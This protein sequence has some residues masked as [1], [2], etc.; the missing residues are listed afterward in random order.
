MEPGTSRLRLRDGSVAL[1]REVRPGDRA[2]LIGGFAELSHESRVFRFLHHVERLEDVD[3]DRFSSPDSRLHVAI[4]ASVSAGAEAVPAGI[5]HF[6]RPTSEARRAELALTV[7][8][9]FQGRGLG[10]LLL[11]RLM[12]IGTDQGLRQ[13][14]ALVHPRNDGMIHILRGL[15]AA[16]RMEEGIR[17][18][19]LP[20]YRRPAD[21]PRGSVGD[22]VRAAYLIESGDGG[23]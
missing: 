14:D 11:G 18:F 19:A 21:Y 6:F 20:L 23:G 8:D 3:A 16:E 17:I 4:G 1:L 15:G 9:R 7:I 5:A 12:R 13:L 10:I 22:A 2:A